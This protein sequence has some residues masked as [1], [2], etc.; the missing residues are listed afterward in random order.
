MLHLMLTKV[1]SWGKRDSALMHEFHG[2]VPTVVNAKAGVQR[3]AIRPA[4]KGAI[5]CDGD[6]KAK[7]LELWDQIVASR[8]EGGFALLKQVQA[9]GLKA[10]QGS[11]LGNAR[12]ADEE[13]LCKPLKGGCQLQGRD[14]PSQAPA[15]HVEVLGETVDADDLVIN[16]QRALSLLLSKGQTQVDLIDQGDA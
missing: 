11:M 3:A 13:V 6:I 7:C 4:V 12:W 1:S 5:G 9:A 8:F 15:G 14:H 16:G 10:S 2:E